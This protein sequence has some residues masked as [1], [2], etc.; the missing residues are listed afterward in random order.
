MQVGQKGRQINSK[1]QALEEMCG[2]AIG[3]GLEHAEGLHSRIEIAL[4]R[5]IAV[6]QGGGS[7][8]ALLRVVDAFFAGGLADAA[9]RTSAITLC[10]K[11]LED[12]HNDTAGVLF[13]CASDK[14]HRRPISA[15]GGRFVEA[16]SC[17]EGAVPVMDPSVGPMVV[18]ARAIDG[19]QRPWVVF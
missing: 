10:S 7:G 9:R 19:D 14:R 4:K 16:D 3:G 8:L 15:S 1:T 6:F 18:V 5:G 13:V 12:S 17:E 2:V 11:P